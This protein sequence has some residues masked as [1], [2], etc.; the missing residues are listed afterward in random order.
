MSY[1]RA[2]EIF[3]DSLQFVDA[4]TDSFQHC[5]GSGLSELAKALEADMTKIQRSL[6]QIETKLRRLG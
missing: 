2:K 4:T 6:S 5:L 1:R 3:S